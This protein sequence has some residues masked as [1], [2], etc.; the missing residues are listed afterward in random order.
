[1]CQPQAS[2]QEVKIRPL[3]LLLVVQIY[4]LP[5]VYQTLNFHP[6]GF[7]LGALNDADDDDV[8]FY[9]NGLPQESR[10]M[11]FEAGDEDH[12]TILLGNRGPV[13]SKVWQT[14]I[15]APVLTKRI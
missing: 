13:P 11:A 1:M 10:R 3:G 4:S 14:L 15:F 12:E 8:D 5:E 2:Q 9:D 6:A 7:G